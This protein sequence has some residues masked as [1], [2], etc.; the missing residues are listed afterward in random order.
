MHR[1]LVV[2][3]AALTSSLARADNGPVP[4]SFEVVVGD[5]IVGEVVYLG[6]YVPSVV[7]RVDGADADV[8]VFGVFIDE[9][10]VTGRD[11]RIFSDADFDAIE[12]QWIAL[13]D[14]ITPGFFSRQP[15]L[16]P[17]RLPKAR[18]LLRRGRAPLPRPTA[19]QVQAHTVDD[20]DDCDANSS[21]LLALLQRCAPQR[22]APAP[23]AVTRFD[24]VADFAARV[25]STTKLR[26][27]WQLECVDDGKSSSCFEL[28]ADGAFD[29]D[30]AGHACAVRVVNVGEAQKPSLSGAKPITEEGCRTLAS[31]LG[32]AC[33][34]TSSCR[35]ELRW[36]DAAEAP[37]QELR[38]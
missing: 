21:A 28:Y 14:A 36:S 22:P 27:Q 32:H 4:V 11:V 31:G 7:G 18:Y 33:R 10:V 34:V 16:C 15:E 1:L 12:G 6:D 19:A 29:D 23:A 8:E 9:M 17:G 37:W 3:V 5:R 2:V 13:H 26:S 20:C 38:R 30:D 35:V 25:D 24:S